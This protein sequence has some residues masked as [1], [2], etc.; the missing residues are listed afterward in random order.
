MSRPPLFLALALVACILAGLAAWFVWRWRRTTLTL[1]QFLLLLL[2][3]AFNRLLWRT[4]I[5]RPLPVPPG[6]GAVI[7]ANHTS[8]IDPLLIQMGT[9]RVVHWMV[10]REYVEHPALAP[11]FRILRS[12]PVG[13]RGIDTAATKL[14]IRLAQQGGLVGL[15]PEGRINQG[16]D[17]LLSGRPGAALIALKANVPVIPCHVA[18]AP[19]NGTVMGPFIM[20]A[21]VRVS[22]GDPIDLTPFQHD[23]P[24]RQGFKDLTHE[25]MRRIAALGG[26]ADFEPELAG[27]VWGPAADEAEA[28]N[29]R[30][31]TEAISPDDAEKA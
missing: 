24:N 1:P 15:F 28:E 16:E 8:S 29:G 4:T 9:D 30:G 26:V 22:V 20:P 7:V 6:T 25:M 11:L 21:R 12:I 19:Y 3:Y 31:G 13:R 10:A 23:G 18:G 27:K 17:V 2:N 5:D 14:A